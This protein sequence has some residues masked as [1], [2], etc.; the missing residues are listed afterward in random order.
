MHKPHFNFKLFFE[1]RHLDDKR[2]PSTGLPTCSNTTCGRVFIPTRKAQYYCE[3]CIDKLEGVD[4]SPVVCT[5]RVV[6]TEVQP[7]AEQP[8]F[9][10]IRRNKKLKALGVQGKE[11]LFK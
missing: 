11:G 9:L 10:T 2:P 3:S 8:H 7:I 4:T 5:C 1:T 6:P